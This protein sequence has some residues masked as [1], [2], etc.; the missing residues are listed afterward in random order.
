MIYI[1]AQLAKIAQIQGR[2]MHCFASL[3]VMSVQFNLI[4]KLPQKI[5]YLLHY[6]SSDQKEQIAFLYQPF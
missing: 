1:R 2:Q 4:K 5:V 3:M 6:V